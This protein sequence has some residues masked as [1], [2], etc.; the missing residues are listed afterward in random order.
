M[1]EAQALGQTCNLIEDIYDELASN[2]HNIEISQINT[3]ADKLAKKL[4]YVY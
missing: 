4:H 2:I 3:L 1:D